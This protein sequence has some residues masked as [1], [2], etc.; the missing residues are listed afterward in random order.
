M[1]TSLQLCQ[2]PVRLRNRDHIKYLLQPKFNV[3]NGDDVSWFNRVGFVGR[4]LEPVDFGAVG[5]IDVGDV[6]LVSVPVNPKV[7][8]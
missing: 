7:R 6:E 8:P 3:A 2:T 4:N 5:R 1:R